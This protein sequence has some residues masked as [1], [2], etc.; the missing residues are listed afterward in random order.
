MTSTVKETITCSVC[1]GL[2][3]SQDKCPKILIC[4]HTFCH[5]CLGNVI[6]QNHLCP[7]CRQDI[8]AASN[9]ELPI[10]YTIKTLA[11]NFQNEEEK[12]KKMSED[13]CK[14]HS[15]QMYF[16][17]FVCL[18]FACTKCIQVYHKDCKD[19]AVNDGAI[20]NAKRYHLNKI[21]DIKIKLGVEERNTQM[22]LFNAYGNCVL[23]KSLWQK[24]C[25]KES[26]EKGIDKILHTFTAHLSEILDANT[27]QE[28]NHAV[29]KVEHYCDVLNVNY[30]L[31]SRH[32]VPTT[33]ALIC[34]KVYLR[35][36][37]F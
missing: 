29:S 5:L 12:R 33:Y 19:D 14:E 7:I 16:K 37:N 26:Y 34:T 27:A 15:L 28:L 32:I 8:Q 2:F 17:C 24:L 36:A 21:N 13:Y 18:K 23:S 9:E 11:E 1:D 30:N 4:G 35:I 6:Q 20:E 3:D 25:Y 10:N 22:A 31:V